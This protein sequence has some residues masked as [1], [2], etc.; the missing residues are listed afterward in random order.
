MSDQK[1]SAGV[2][3]GIFLASTLMFYIP[4]V[5]SISAWGVSAKLQSTLD[6]AKDIIER[7][8]KLAEANAKATYLTV[9]W[10]NRL[11]SPPATEKQKVLDETDA[12]LRALGVDEAERKQIARPLV[13]LIGIDIYR[14]YYTT[15]ERLVFWKDTNER[16]AVAANGTSEAKTDYQKLINSIAAWRSLN[17]ANFPSNDLNNYDLDEYL[18]RATPTAILDDAQKTAAENFRKKLL[19]LYAG[20]VA[21]GGYTPETAGFLD[22]NL[23]ENYLKPADARVK[24]LFSVEVDA[25]RPRP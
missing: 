13:A 6:E 9:A 10:G 15:M 19:A 8:K 12:Q 25:A 14:V 1:G 5:V 18:I 22:R 21:K 2:L 20:C 16:V 3:A 24:E 4:R 11:G 17:S 23:G 7:L